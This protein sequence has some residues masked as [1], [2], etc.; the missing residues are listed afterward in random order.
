MIELPF[1]EFELEDEPVETRL[2][3][4]E[5]LLPDVRSWEEL[6]GQS[7]PTPESIDGT[8]PLF[9]AHNPVEAFAL[10]FGERE[11]QQI[12]VN[13]HVEIDFEQEGDDDYGVIERT[14]EAKL[15]IEPLRIATSLEKRLKGEEADILAAI[16][17]AIEID[18]YG[19]L[20]KAPGGFEMPLG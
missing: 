10:T 2:H 5:I 13:I 12:H 16:R 6:S 20:A 11:G 18:A 17:P 14:F 19:P 1:T 15:N 9:D 3:L 7:S 8:L 4:N